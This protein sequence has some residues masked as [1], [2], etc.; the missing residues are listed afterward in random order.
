MML[1][2]LLSRTLLVDLETTKSGK[3]RHIGAVFN[4]HVVETTSEASIKHILSQLEDLA[5]AAEFVLGHNLLGH[6]FPVLQSTYPKLAVL[7]KPVID[8]L[9]LS[10]LAFPQNPYHRLV[11]DYKLVRSSV[12]NPVADARLATSVFRDQWES[13][14]EAKARV[15]HLI[16]FYRFCFEGSLFNGFSGEGLAAVF[17]AVGAKG[18]VSSEAALGFFAEKAAGIVCKH[19]ILETAF[20]LLE[21][22]VRRPALA[23]CL[24]WLQVAGANS[25]LP[26]WVRYRFPEIASILTRLRQTPCGDKS[27]RYCREQHDPEVNLERFFGF[28]GF[29]KKPSTR[30]GESLQRGI[31]VNGMRG[32]P[33]LAILPTGGGKSVCYQLPALVRHRCRGMMTVVISPLQALMKDQV[34]NLMKLTGTPFAAAISGLQTPPERGE[35]LE[36]IRLG[37]VAIL[38]IAPEQLRSRSVRSV[39]S[40]R[41]IGCWVFDEAHCVSKWGHDFRPDYLYAARFI[42]EFASDYSQPVP[43]VC[44]F[45]ATAK[46][47]VIDDITSHFLDE[48]GQDL[49]LFAGGVER[50]NI[51]FEVQP[52]GAAEKLERTFQTLSESFEEDGSGS[53]IVYAETRKKTEEIRDFLRNQG[54][55]AGAFHG[56]LDAKEK[57]DIID[58]FV[59]GQ[60]PVICAT[61]AFGMGID[62]PNVRLVLHFEMPGSLENYIQEAGRAGRDGAPARCV[63]LYHPDDANLQFSKGAMSEVKEREIK[64]ILRALRRAK[65]NR[66]GEIVITS[67]ELLPT[68]F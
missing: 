63:L 20:P 43:P 45:T 5:S 53:A 12:N 64:R 49:K 17:A 1:D 25:V 68:L 36:R 56:G 37:D 48:L 41:E 55:N 15:A 57:R 6:D 27:C 11:K 66:F 19:A 22:G 13:F 21:D 59:A 10:P 38:Y 51:V 32:N 2:E 3:I 60:T 14:F 23:Y 42:R 28:A 7:R 34:D 40:Q 33:L 67:D 8:T 29:R 58:S 54:I 26:P 62:K 31:V 44:C 39:L 18:F 61:N 52:V 35:V 4:N 46:S 47:D 24:A 16:D 30:E 50:E 9:Y 65:R